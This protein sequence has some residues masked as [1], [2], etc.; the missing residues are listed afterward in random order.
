MKTTDLKPCPFCGEVATGEIDNVEKEFRIVCLNCRAE[1]RLSF[2]EAHLD[3]GSVI[4]F[5]EAR[6]VI[7]G[8][9]ELWNERYADDE[10][11]D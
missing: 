8:L 10:Q 4:G 5:D 6:Q 7:D 9:T 11:K 1:M 2:A 3:D